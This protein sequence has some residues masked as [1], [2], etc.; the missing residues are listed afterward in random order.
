MSLLHSSY[1]MYLQ[2]GTLLSC[3][4]TTYQTA[5]VFPCRYLIG[6]TIPTSVRVL[7]EAIFT[8][9]V[10]ISVCCQCGHMSETYM[11]LNIPLSCDVFVAEAP[12]AT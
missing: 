12:S 6:G 8:P 9:L 2:L 3:T 5:L 1:G 11:Y 10:D 7:V 4:C